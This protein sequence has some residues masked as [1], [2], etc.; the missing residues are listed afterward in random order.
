MTK[1]V[2]KA[3]CT[4]AQHVDGDGSLGMG[5]YLVTDDGEQV[6]ALG[7]GGG[8]AHCCNRLQ[9]FKSGRRG[10]MMEWRLRMSWMMMRWLV[11]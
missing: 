10:M 8:C 3:S 2:W 6:A 7:V 5:T 4:M 1:Y 11:V 9:M